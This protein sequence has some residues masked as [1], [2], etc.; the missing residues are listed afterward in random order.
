MLNNA[1]MPTSEVIVWS[2]MLGGFLTLAVV[3]VSDLLMNPTVGAWR[4][5][6]FVVLTGWSCLIMSGLASELFPEIPALTMAVM[7]VSMAPLSGA[8]ALTYLSFWLG[9]KRDDR[10]VYLAVVLVSLGLVL[11]SV[12]ATACVLYGDDPGSADPL[13]GAGVVSVLGALVGLWITLRAALLGDDL[14]RW[15]VLACLFLVAMVVGMFGQALSPGALTWPLMALIAFCTLCHFLLV[16]ALTVQRNRVNKQLIR[17][18][19]RAASTD[20][21][22]GLYTGSVLVSKVDDAFW[23][24]TRLNRECAV[25]CLHLGNLYELG[26]SAGHGVEQQILSAMTARIRRA[27]GFRYVVGLY[28]PRCFVVV[29]S[30]VKKEQEVER[31]VLRLRT[32]LTKPLKVFGLK[33]ARHTFQPR[34]GI[35]IANKTATQTDPTTVM[36]MAERRALGQSGATRSADADTAEDS[37]PTAAGTL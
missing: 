21:T 29:I 11:T 10:G 28:H 18:A 31:L 12:V 35:G 4:A 30:A 2:C 27:V 7:K 14:A 5:L 23:R 20:Q 17:Q 33:D 15:M 3:A 24:S 6:V 1:G 26:E 9:V 36:D 34:F 25:V 16:T 8:L 19:K 13:M 22:T 37:A 32:L